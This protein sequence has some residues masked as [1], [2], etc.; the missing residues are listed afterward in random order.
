[1]A[2]SH[3]IQLVDSSVDVTVLHCSAG[4]VLSVRWRCQPLPALD[5]PKL[6]TFSLAAIRVDSNQL[7]DA[8]I[9]IG[10]E[11]LLQINLHATFT[12]LFRS[13]LKDGRPEHTDSIAA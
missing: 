12:V 5:T 1:M 13:V 11:E 10:V 4:E 9:A 2:R 8:L 7:L 3:I 6:P